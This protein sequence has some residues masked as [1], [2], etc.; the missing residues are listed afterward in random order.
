LKK[1]MAL[2]D[3][4][5]V[6]IRNAA[7]SSSDGNME[8]VR[9]V[10]NT[11]SSHL[12]GSKTNPYGEL[13]RFPVPVH[14]AGPLLKWADLVKMDVEGHEKE[15]VLHTSR[16]HWSDTDAMMEVGSAENAVA[17]YNHFSTLGVSM[18]SQKGGWQ[19][20]C[21]LSDVPTSCREGSLFVTCGSSMPWH[22]GETGEVDHP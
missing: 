3:C 12:A 16:D 11:T 1:N 22:R 15:I 13:Q 21:S 5:S 6:E 10:G 8:F 14:A 20:V 9:V 4:R 18:F 17:L 2:N 7:V 19:K